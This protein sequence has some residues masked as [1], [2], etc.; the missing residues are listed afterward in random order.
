MLVCQNKHFRMSIV[1][2]CKLVYRNERGPWTVKAITTKS[3]AEFSAKST[4]FKYSHRQRKKNPHCSS[5]GW[6][7]A[8]KAASILEYRSHPSLRSCILLV[9][10]RSVIL[11]VFLHEL[12][13]LTSIQTQTR[14]HWGPS[15][16]YQK[17]NVTLL[18]WPCHN[19]HLQRVGAWKSMQ[20]YSNM[21][22][23]PDGN[24]AH[25]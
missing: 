1:S 19:T 25:W 4:I 21:E 24:F 15:P 23:L 17:Y 16:A 11:T 2:W 22:R 3:K 8:G 7:L 13:A 5:T 20:C 6:I 14:G 10:F 18:I 12:L 9:W